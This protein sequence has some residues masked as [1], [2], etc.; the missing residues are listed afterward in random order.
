MLQSP[1]RRRPEYRPRNRPAPP[2]LPAAPAGG[3]EFIQVVDRR[4]QG[5]GRAAQAGELLL[6]RLGGE[7]APRMGIG[8]EDTDAR[9]RVTF[10]KLFYGWT[11]ARYTSSARISS[12][13]AKCDANVNGKP[14]IAAILRTEFARSEQPDRDP[15]SR[16][17]HS[18]DHLAWLQRSQQGLQFHDM[19]GQI[20]GSR[21]SACGSLIGAGCAAEAKIDAAPV[22]RFQRTELLCDDQRRM[23]WQHHA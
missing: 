1:V 5:S 11:G 4:R 13:G 10:G 15:Q 23:V 2:R 20:L 8:G 12:E 9:H 18:P 3:P 16:T 22:K 19:M 21:R 6:L 14:S 17:W 7:P